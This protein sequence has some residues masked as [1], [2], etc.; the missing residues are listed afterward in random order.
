MFLI[1]FCDS[2]EQTW[3]ISFTCKGAPGGQQFAQYTI[4]RDELMFGNLITMKSNLGYGTRD[5]L[6]YKRRSGNSIATL[7]EIEYDVDANA[8]ISSNAEERE[9]RLVLS[10]DQITERT[11]DI[12]PIKLPRTVASNS[13]HSID[14]SLDDYKVWLN[15]MHRQGQ[16]MGKLCCC[17]IMNCYIILYCNGQITNSSMAFVDFED[18]YRDDTVKTYKEWLRVQGQLDQISNIYLLFP[19]CQPT[20][21]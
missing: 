20:Y 2:S 15:N 14:E 21:Y 19:K 9:V 13:E 10:R 18:I 6:Y 8:M 4:A 12:T 1:T 3:T 16:G 17:P 7:N 11:V 5:Y